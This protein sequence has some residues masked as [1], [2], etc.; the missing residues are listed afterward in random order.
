MQHFTVWMYCTSIV[1]RGGLSVS[2]SIGRYPLAV[3]LIEWID[4]KAADMV[5]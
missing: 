1:A 4:H 2:D 3:A 5:N